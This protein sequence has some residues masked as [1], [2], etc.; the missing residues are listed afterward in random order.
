M[1]WHDI[2]SVGFSS[3]KLLNIRSI[4]YMFNQFW[5][6]DVSFQHKFQF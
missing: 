2:D 6:L 5:H 1:G 4:T 3:E